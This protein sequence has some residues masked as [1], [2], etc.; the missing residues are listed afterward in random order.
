VTLDEAIGQAIR[1]VRDGFDMTQGQLAEQ[2]GLH[3]MSLSKIERGK[4][5]VKLDTLAS[6]AKALTAARPDNPW[7]PSDLVRFAEGVLDAANAKKHK[8]RRK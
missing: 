5:H 1:M 3:K 7:R 4:G 6:I 8:P 2:A